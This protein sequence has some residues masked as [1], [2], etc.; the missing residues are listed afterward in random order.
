MDFL[1]KMGSL[2]SAYIDPGE[3]TN[4]MSMFVQGVSAI[5]ACLAEVTAIPLH[6]ELENKIRSH[7]ARRLAALAHEKLNFSMAPVPFTY[8]GAGLKSNSFGSSQQFTGRKLW[9]LL[10]SITIFAAQINSALGHFKAI[11][12]SFFGMRAGK[13]W[14]L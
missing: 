13:F 9:L 2:F 8:R 14:V 3:I 11:L 12:C 7:I 6:Q 4:M 5:V 1:V 10:C